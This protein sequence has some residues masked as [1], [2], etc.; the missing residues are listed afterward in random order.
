MATLTEQLQST[1]SPLAAGGSW[2]GINTT[3]PP[4]YPY[5]IFNRIVSST[6][7]TL[8]GPSNLQNTRVQ[9]DVF[10]LRQSDASAIELAVEQAMTA[11]TAFGS[12]Q[13]SQQDTYEAEVKAFRCSADFSV[14]SVN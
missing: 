5:I 9:V 11:A 7:N 8:S 10:S 3:E 14:W 12:I 2:Y 4:V 13:I 6:N 1:L